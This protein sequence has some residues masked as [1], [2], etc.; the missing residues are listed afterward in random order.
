M[1]RVSSPLFTANPVP[2]SH[3]L[4]SIEARKLALPD[5][6]RDFVWEPTA[7]LDLLSTLERGFPAGSLLFIRC[8]SENFL[9]AR[10]VAGAPALG[11]ATPAELVLDGQQRLTSLYGA[12]YGRGEYRFFVDVKKLSGGA[13][14][15]DAAFFR[16]ADRLEGLDQKENQAA[17]LIFPMGQ[18]YAPS[19]GFP[20]WSTS[21]A[22]LASSE[23]N[24]IVEFLKQ[25]QAVNKLH[26]EQIATYAFPV[27]TLPESTKPEA[28]CKIFSTINSTG[29]RLTTFDLLA[30]KLW[31]EGFRLRREWNAAT[32]TENILKEFLGDD[33]Y[34]VLQAIAVR[35]GRTPTPAGILELNG[36]I[37]R[38]HWEAVLIGMTAVLRFLR[39]EC[40][41]RRPSYLPYGP[42]LVPMAGTWELIQQAQGPE[43][44]ARRAK[45]ARWFWCSSFGQRYEV[46]ANSRVAQ[47]YKELVAWLEGGA[48]PRVV[49]GLDFNPSDL[50]EATRP[51]A[52]I[53]RATLALILRHGARDFHSGELLSAE[54]LRENGVDDHHVV[55]TRS[56]AAAGHGDHLLSSV[57]NRALIDPTTNK[58]IS[59]KNPSIYLREIEDSQGSMNSVLESHLLPTALDGP[60]R[61]DDL[62]G[63]LEW[64]QSRVAEEVRTLTGWHPGERDAAISVTA[65]IR[66]ALQ[67]MDIDVVED[68]SAEE[69]YRGFSVRFKSRRRLWCGLWEDARKRWA[70]QGWVWLHWSD[71]RA[72]SPSEKA[73][74]S[75]LLE[76]VGTG[77]AFLDENDEKARPAMALATSDP[78]VAAT[79]INAFIDVVRAR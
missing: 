72:P 39:D 57:L 3:L 36:E 5:F 42:S 6:Q 49:D 59:N 24:S 18:L 25:L 19:G 10:E 69:G 22:E 28:V 51:N 17:R 47:D 48:T 40:G 54:R 8:G 58:R 15:E 79:A 38:A 52:G 50:R 73:A 7:T 75:K 64:R 71:L 31:P 13:T 76:T 70:D 43:K 74:W 78:T 14:F 1:V 37:F 65:A 21:I 2:L 11:G 62:I 9:E 45:L 53:Y 68:S 20:E 26:F 27:V 66:K 41:V 33:G 67:D 55:P 30:A 60:L 77:K 23:N 12:L 61:K 46:S 32:E 29:V 4:S 34:P 35:A 44:G 16:R 56:K 63:L